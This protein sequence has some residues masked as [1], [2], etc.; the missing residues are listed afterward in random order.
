MSRTVAKSPKLDLKLNLSPPRENPP[1]ESPDV[2]TPSPTSSSSEMSI[3]GSCVSSEAEGQVVQKWPRNSETTSMMLV[4]CP[5]CLM[6]VMLSEVD[7]KCPKCKSTVLLD[8]LKDEK[9]RA[10]AKNNTSN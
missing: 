10:Y 4:G 1:D 8:F 9:N 6:Y 2:S 5:R 3:E 7:P